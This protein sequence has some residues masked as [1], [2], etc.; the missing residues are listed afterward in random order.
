M[1]FEPGVDDI[2][3][4]KI[5]K[6]LCRMDGKDTRTKNKIG[7]GLILTS[8]IKMLLNENG[9][10]HLVEN[11]K[12]FSAIQQHT[13]HISD[14]DIQQLIQ[15]ARNIGTILLFTFEHYRVV[16]RSKVSF[17]PVQIHHF[18]QPTPMPRFI[19]P[20]LMQLLPDYSGFNKLLSESVCALPCIRSDSAGSQPFQA[21]GCCYPYAY[22]C[23]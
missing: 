1:T 9:L 6:L 23:K 11:S 18:Q 2:L 19:S 13:I 8:Q 7:E 17:E 14:D 10:V 16:K 20:L 21:N 15:L 3:R 4:A 22:F 12:S 5:D